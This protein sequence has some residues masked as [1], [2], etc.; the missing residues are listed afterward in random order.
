MTG[1]ATGLLAGLVGTTALEIH[2]PNL[3]AWHILVA[4][5]GVGVLGAIGGFFL[6]LAAENKK[7]ISRRP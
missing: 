6:G 4:H 1:A 2:C 5:L 3:D 7:I